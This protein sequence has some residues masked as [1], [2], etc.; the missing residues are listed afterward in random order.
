MFEFILVIGAVILAVFLES[1]K[2]Q[3]KKNSSKY[4]KQKHSIND[5]KNKKVQKSK[6]NSK[7]IATNSNAKNIINKKRTT[8]N[9]KSYKQEYWE[10]SNVTPIEIIQNSNVSNELKVEIL[11][12]IK[13]DFIENPKKAF[14]FSEIFNRKY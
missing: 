9:S 3:S 10:F 13:E 12:E 14:L 8:E 6:K 11:S 5:S 2:K 4:Y 7:R 1:S